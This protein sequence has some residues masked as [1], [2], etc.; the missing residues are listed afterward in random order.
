MNRWLLWDYSG[1]SWSVG[2]STC[3]VS[4]RLRPG[5]GDDMRTSMI[6]LVSY[7]SVVIKRTIQQPHVTLEQLQRLGMHTFDPDVPFC[8]Y[9]VVLS[10]NHIS[11]S[12]IDWS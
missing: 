6:Q 9:L 2:F 7:S 12:P 1:I 8:R 3:T 5:F 10:M 4:N 11:V